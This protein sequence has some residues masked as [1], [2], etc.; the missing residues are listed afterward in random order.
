MK[1]ILPAPP[2]A[3]TES[4]A[5]CTGDIYGTISSEFGV[6]CRTSCLIKEK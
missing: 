6:Y 5:F 4:V 1:L 3:I 2:A